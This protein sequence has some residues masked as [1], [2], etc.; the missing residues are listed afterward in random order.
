M[1]E[2]ALR[3]HLYEDKSKKGRRND[4]CR[5]LLGHRLP[6]RHRGLRPRRRRHLRDSFLA[7]DVRPETHS[8]S[9]AWK[10]RGVTLAV[11]GFLNTVDQAFTPGIK[12][13]DAPA[14][15]LER[16]QSRLRV[17]RP[18]AA[19]ADAASILVRDRWALF[20]RPGRKGA[21]AVGDGGQGPS[22]CGTSARNASP[23]SSPFSR[24]RSTD[25]SSCRR[26][27]PAS[28]AATGEFDFAALYA[29]SQKPSGKVDVAHWISPALTIGSSFRGHDGRGL[30]VTRDVQTGEL[31]LL[32]K[33]WLSCTLDETGE[34]MDLQVL[35]L[36]D[37]ASSVQNLS[38]YHLTHRI[39]Q[40]CATL[41]C[42]LALQGH[43]DL[44]VLCICS[45]P[46]SSM[47]PR[48]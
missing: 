4:D 18:R 26:S 11:K 37:G 17:G 40:W 15:R 5:G 23:S 35:V 34:V 45:L 48:R 12:I 38:Q 27:P 33:P 2:P 32:Q 6:L 42:R 14:V 44:S 22:G 8:S 47:T 25:A 28:K 7:P 9:E 13:D 31:L 39:A 46:A 10:R 19:L 36:K 29:A 41:L 3:E 30:S 16:G 43:P 24:I 21:P 20:G 1:R